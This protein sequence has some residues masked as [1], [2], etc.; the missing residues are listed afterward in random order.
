MTKEDAPL[1]LCSDCTLIACNGPYGMDISPRDLDTLV[2]DVT[3][4]GPY[5][6]P[7]FDSESGDGIWEFSRIPCDSCHTQLAGYRARFAILSERKT[8]SEEEMGT[9]K[10]Y[11]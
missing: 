4:L 2:Q 3:K 7:D 6:V 8:A 10:K 1:Y 9:I 5:L 11:N